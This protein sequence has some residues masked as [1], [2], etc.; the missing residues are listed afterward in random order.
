[1]DI[2][3][4]STRAA[5]LAL[6][7]EML[8]LWWTHKMGWLTAADLAAVTGMHSDVAARV[9]K[10]LTKG[11]MVL[12]DHFPGSKTRYYRLALAG[13]DRL[14][15]ALKTSEYRSGEQ[16]ELGTYF[17]HRHLANRYI[18]ETVREHSSNGYVPGFY[19]EH[20]IVAKRAPLHTCSRKIAD[21]LV[22]HS[23]EDG[24]VSVD[25]LEAEH[26]YKAKPDYK[27]LLRFILRLTEPRG[28]RVLATRGEWQDGKAFLLGEVVLICGNDSPHLRRICTAI[29]AIVPYLYSDQATRLLDDL[30]VAV[31]VAPYHFDRQAVGELLDPEILETC[32]TDTDPHNSMWIEESTV[33]GTT[34]RPKPSWTE[35][36]VKQ[37]GLK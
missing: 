26:S 15:T 18:L 2:A 12:R 27:R 10:R 7:N 33:A 28:K 29:T 32:K 21:G 8:A 34:P 37:L 14:N 24:T 11:S 30:A 23:Q 6:Q 17:L 25:W 20:E 22:M 13:A 4:Y 1:M 36:I 3:N 5:E 9:F 35:A 31:E 16:F 19:S